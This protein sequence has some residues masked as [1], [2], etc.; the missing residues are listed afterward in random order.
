MAVA[1]WGGNP[2]PMPDSR[3]LIALIF[4]LA[5]ALSALAQSTPAPNT[6]GEKITLE[7]AIQRA[8]AKN[9]AI[10]VQ[11]FESSIAAARVTEAF[12]KFDPVLNAV[13]PPALLPGASSG[14]STRGLHSPAL[15]G[16]AGRRPNTLTETPQQAAGN[17]SPFSSAGCRRPARPGTRRRFLPPPH[18]GRP[19]LSSRGR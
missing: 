7:Q 14:D 3:H 16:L 9:F 8:L 17:V 19:G 12:G 13:L 6:E 10:K 4:P 18:A 1:K 11:G 2:P 5:L 15:V